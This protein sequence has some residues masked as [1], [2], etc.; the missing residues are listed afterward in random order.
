MFK[1]VSFATIPSA[2]LGHNGELTLVTR[3]PVNE[4]VNIQPQS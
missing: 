3:H 1:N 4:L 2:V